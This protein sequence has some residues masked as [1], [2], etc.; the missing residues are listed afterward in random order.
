MRYSKLFGKTV[1][2]FPKEEVSVNAKF[3][4]KAGFIDKLMAVHSH[5]CRWGSVSKKIE[6][7]VREEMDKTAPTKCWCRF[8]TLK[9]SGMKPAAGTAR[10]R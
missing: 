2:D 1:R 4:I 6:Q 3:L 5:Y 9:K 10:K 7:I 8:Y